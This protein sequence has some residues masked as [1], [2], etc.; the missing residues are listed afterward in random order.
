MPA[1]QRMVRLLPHPDAPS[2]PSVSDPA[3]SWTSSSNVPKRFLMSTSKLMQT[4][5]S[6]RRRYFVV[7]RDHR[8]MNRITIKLKMMMITVQNMATSQ[9]PLIHSK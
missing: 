3:W 2:R 6:T 1:I 5:Y 4:P 8:L 9:F 7:R